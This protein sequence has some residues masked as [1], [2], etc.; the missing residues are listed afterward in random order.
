MQYLIISKAV[1]NAISGPP[2]QAIGV[3]EN[4][5]LPSLKIL[6][7]GERNKKFVGGA[8]AGQRGWAIVADFANN[9]EAD[10]WIRRLPF[11][12]VETSEI[13]PLVSFQSELD[14]SNEIVQAMK[15]MLKK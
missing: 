9:E 8:I 6:A 12:V 5:A 14:F 3:L 13:I 11:W 10:K 15:S 1:G 7:E 2:E 4:V